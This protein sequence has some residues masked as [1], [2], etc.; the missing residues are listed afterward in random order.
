MEFR[1][2]GNFQVGFDLFSSFRGLSPGGT[3]SQGS[4]LSSFSRIS[5]VF[6]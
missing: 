5:P 4:S 2:V 6:G 3:V 1:E